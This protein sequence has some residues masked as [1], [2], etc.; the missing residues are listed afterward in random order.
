LVGEQRDYEA[1]GSFFGLF[2]KTKFAQ[3]YHAIDDAGVTVRDKLAGAHPFDVFRARCDDAE[4]VAVGFHFFINYGADD[5]QQTRI[6]TDAGKH[7]GFLLTIFYLCSS[8][9]IRG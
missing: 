7:L 9:F 3:R 4:F 5:R 2:G 8:V 6:N 1:A